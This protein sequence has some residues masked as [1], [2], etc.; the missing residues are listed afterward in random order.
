[1]REIT[2]AILTGS[3]EEEADDVTDAA[4]DT[5]DDTAAE[6]EVQSTGETVVWLTTASSNR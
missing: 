1:M 3:D 4:A 6:V 2:W 5:T